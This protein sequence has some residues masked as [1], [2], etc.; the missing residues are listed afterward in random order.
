MAKDYK[1][2]MP[3]IWVILEVGKK[4]TMQ[5]IGYYFQK[6]WESICLLMKQIYPKENTL[7][8]SHQQICQRPQG[9]ISSNDKRN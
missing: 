8:H 7:Y 1:N 3:L 9:G 2:N 4:Q 6:I 5:K